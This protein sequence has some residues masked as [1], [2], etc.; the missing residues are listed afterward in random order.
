MKLESHTMHNKIKISGIVVVLITFSIYYFYP[1][2]DYVMEMVKPVNP[3]VEKIEK[4]ENTP[5][6]ENIVV[7]KVEEKKEN[8]VEEKQVEEKGK[9]LFSSTDSSGRYTIQLIN[10]VDIE[11]RSKDSTRYVPMIGEIEEGSDLNTFTISISEDYLDYLSSMTIRILDVTNKERKIET[12]AY[13]L[14][15]LDVNNTYNIKLTVLGDTVNGHIKSSERM[16]DFMLNAMSN[17]GP[18]II[19]QEEHN[20]SVL[21]NEGKSPSN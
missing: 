4:I 8:V 14:G 18:V 16:P 3:V 21:I 11:I 2:D 13:F 7:P 12:A 17:S 5:K 20:K 19:N 9:V 1:K 10:S 15:T 6:K